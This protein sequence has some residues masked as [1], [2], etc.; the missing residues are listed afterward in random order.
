MNRLNRLA[1]LYDPT[2]LCYGLGKRTEYGR[3]DCDFTFKHT[4]AVLAEYAPDVN[5]DAVVA[6]LERLGCHDD[7]ETMLN[8][9]PDTGA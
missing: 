5:A 4:R 1:K 7:L 3:R 9:C 6:E 2:A 8:I